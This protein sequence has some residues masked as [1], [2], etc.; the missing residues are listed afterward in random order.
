VQSVSDQAVGIG[1]VKGVKPDQQLVKVESVISI[2]FIHS[3]LL[4]HVL[5]IS[6]TFESALVYKLC[7]LVC[8]TSLFLNWCLFCSMHYCL[9]LHNVFRFKYVYMFLVSKVLKLRLNSTDFIL[10]FS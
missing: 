7:Q 2:S 10:A 6:V 1:V 9:T 5:A 4:H 8:A 3:L